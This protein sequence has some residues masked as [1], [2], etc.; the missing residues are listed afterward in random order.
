MSKRYDE[1]T[2]IVEDYD[3]A[4]DVDE[5]LVCSAGTPGWGGLAHSTHTDFRLAKIAQ[6]DLLVVY[7]INAWIEHILP[8]GPPGIEEQLDAARRMS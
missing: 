6:I 2:G 4:T 8:F 5:Y 1:F 7:G 3:P